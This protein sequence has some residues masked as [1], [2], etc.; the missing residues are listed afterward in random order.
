MVKS[1]HPMLFMQLIFNW[2]G[3]NSTPTFIRP[4]KAVI[5]LTDDFLVEFAGVYNTKSNDES[6]RVA[7]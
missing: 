2:K 1:C 6:N 7:K 5:Y 3:L 4:R